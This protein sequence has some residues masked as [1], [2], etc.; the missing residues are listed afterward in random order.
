MWV[1]R[2]CAGGFLRRREEGNLFN[3]KGGI[4]DV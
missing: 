2:F 3:R 4:S 1:R